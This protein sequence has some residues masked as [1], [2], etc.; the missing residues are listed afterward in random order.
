[1][2]TDQARLYYFSYIT[3]HRN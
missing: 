2:S 3:S 1:M